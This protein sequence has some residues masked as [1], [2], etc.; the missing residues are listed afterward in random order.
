MPT[1]SIN[2]ADIRLA[3]VA[4]QVAFRPLDTPLAGT[5]GLIVSG[6]KSVLTN[7]QGIGSITL[8]P[9][10]YEV[11][12]YGIAGNT[13][14]F[15]IG[16]P[17]NNSTYTLV[18][19]RNNPIPVPEIDVMA[20]ATQAEVD[21]GTDENKAVTPKTL[22][23]WMGSTA[24]IDQS[25]VENLSTASV[26]FAGNAQEA[27]TAYEAP[28]VPQSENGLS[29]ANTAWVH[30][31]LAGQK[32][33]IESG[34]I[35]P[36]NSTYAHEAEWAATSIAIRSS[37]IDYPAENILR[38]DSLLDA[39]KVSGTLDIACIPILPSQRQIASPGALTDLTTEQQAQIGQG[40]VV[41][42]TDG[43]RWVYSGGTGDKTLE[44]SYVKLADITPDW[45]TISGKPIFGTAS[46][47]DVSAF[48]PALSSAG[49]ATA[50]FVEAADEVIMRLGGVV[51]RITFTN[52]KSWIRSWA[53]ALY[54]TAAQGTLA[55]T[56]WQGT[57]VE[58]TLASDT[59][60][61][62]NTNVLQASP[63]QVALTAGT[64]DIDYEVF[65]ISSAY[66]TL[67]TQI[68]FSFSGGYSS[69]LGS[70][71]LARDASTT[72]SVNGSWTTASKSIRRLI[73]NLAVG[74]ASYSTKGRARLVVTSTGT[75]TVSGAL[76]TNGTGTI[77]FAVG[78]FVRAAK[79]S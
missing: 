58:Y 25:Q 68:G 13:D 14:K 9:G 17:D 75:L 21:A 30:T 37:G 44:A 28:T 24:R 77:I 73:V 35:V 59:V 47:I 19:V 3:P 51:K 66:A 78:S 74:T 7:A 67:G 1:I 38:T 79:I 20:P 55:G 29:I 31:A 4:C 2:L 57:V 39:T 26:A 64:W 6:M 41:T 18:Q 34:V 63:I 36:R 65:A 50:P 76:N 53:D 12:F 48:E 27:N 70:R 45:T 69:D 43:L 10:N 56:A 52:F 49:P 16:V 22:N 61:A 72:D 71:Q 23:D 46:L 40:T 5:S 60:V 33:D 42:T 11:S 8:A 62:T 15:N 32:N 54:A